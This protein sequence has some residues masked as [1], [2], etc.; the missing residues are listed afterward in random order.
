MSNPVCVDFL[1]ELDSPYLDV[2]LPFT[3]RTNNFTSFIIASVSLFSFI[4]WAAV[5]T[6]VSAISNESV[7]IFSKS[8]VY[9][10]F[11]WRFSSKLFPS[12]S[13][14]ISFTTFSASSNVSTYVFVSLF[15]ATCM[16]L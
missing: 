7:F 13:A 12:N 6:V 2:I 3:G 9:F 8:S 14:F 11:I 5:S 16:L 1:S 15:K 4:S 10:S